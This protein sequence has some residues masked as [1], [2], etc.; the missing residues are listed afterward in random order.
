MLS[1]RDTVLQTDEWGFSSSFFANLGSRNSSFFPLDCF[2]SSVTVLPSPPSFLN[3]LLTAQTASA[4]TTTTSAIRFSPFSSTTPVA[5]PFESYVTDEMADEKWNLAPWDSAI[6]WRDA[7]TVWNPPRGYH[8][9]SALQDRSAVKFYLGVKERT[10]PSHVSV[11]C[12]SLSLSACCAELE[13]RLTY[14][15][16]PGESKGELPRYL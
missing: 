13:Q 10:I 16:V 1:V 6:F 12:K 5:F 8:W 4:L 11:H 7:G 9:M 3:R 14:V 2:I 15:Y